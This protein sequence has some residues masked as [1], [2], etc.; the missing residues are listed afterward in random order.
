M[1]SRISSDSACESSLELPGPSITDQE[2]REEISKINAGQIELISFDIV[3]E[4]LSNVISVDKALIQIEFLLEKEQATQ[5]KKAMPRSFDEPRQ[6]GNIRKFQW[7]VESLP[8]QTNS[9]FSK[10]F[11]NPSQLM[12]YG[13]IF[14]VFIKHVGYLV[15]IELD[16]VL[17]QKQGKLVFSV[18]DSYGKVSYDKRTFTI[19]SLEKERCSILT[20]T[21]RK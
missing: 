12:L 3:T 9:Y 19:E 21:L 4:I 8:G 14:S 2:V 13:I 5:T 15:S 20:N 6:S 16:R 17:S 11:S 10:H 1:T 7:F 18:S